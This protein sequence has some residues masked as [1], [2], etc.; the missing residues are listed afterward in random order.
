[1]TSND[2]LKVAREEFAIAGVPILSEAKSVEEL[3]KEGLPY[4]FAT[5][6]IMETK[7]GG[8]YFY[9][10][11]VEFYQLTSLV[12]DPSIRV[13]TCTWSDTLEGISPDLGLVKAHLASL[14][15]IFIKGY[16]SVNPR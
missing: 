8:N 16:F 4:L 3:R 12:R 10:I 7:F 11:A 1:M 13:H 15:E 9:T 5:P 6:I 14:L 2:L